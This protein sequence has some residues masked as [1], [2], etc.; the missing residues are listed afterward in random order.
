VTPARPA[1]RPITMPERARMRAMRRDG[2]SLLKIAAALGISERTVRRHTAGITTRAR[3][4]RYTPPETLAEI[5]RLRLTMSAPE[6]AAELGCH[7]ATVYR[8]APGARPVYRHP[9]ALK[10]AQRARILAAM[11]S[12]VPGAEIA[13]WFGISP[14]SP[15][16]IACRERR[17][18]QEEARAAQEARQ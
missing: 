3:H 17:R 14:N 4:P 8:H 18:R 2:V 9:H 7:E 15:K 12:G 5:R 13:A 10:P 11:N 1:F 6:V 16:V